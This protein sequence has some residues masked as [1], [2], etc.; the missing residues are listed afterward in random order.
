MPPELHT[1]QLSRR[2]LASQMGF[3]WALTILLAGC[4]IG[5]LGT[6][7]SPEVCNGIS[8]E[9]G[10][11]DADLPTYAGIDCEAVGREFGPQYGERALR[12]FDGPAIVDGN[13]RSVQLFHA[14]VVSVQLANKH[15]RDNGL[16]A[17]CEADTFLAA[18]EETL[19]AGFRERI[20]DFLYEETRQSSYAEWR[21]DMLRLLAVIDQEE[22]LPYAP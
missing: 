17:D 11:C 13:A 20:G 21:A 5:D 8:A 6:S 22:E 7:P 2:T 9:V 1:S 15:L 14:A 19:P 10:G 16:V 12:I 4:G 18:A 3:A